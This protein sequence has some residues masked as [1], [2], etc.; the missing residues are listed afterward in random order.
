MNRQIPT[1]ACALSFAF[2]FAVASAANAATPAAV[3]DSSIPGQELNTTQGI[4]SI[5]INYP[6]ARFSNG[7]L[8]I[9]SG[10]SS[11]GRISLD[12]LGLTSVSVLVKYTDFSGFTG[13]DMQYPPVLT[14]VEISGYEV[15]IYAENDAT[16]FQFYW[17]ARGS[18]EMYKMNSAPGPGFLPGRSG[19]FLLSYSATEGIRFSLGIS[20]SSM[21]ETDRADYKYNDRVLTHVSIGG[22]IDSQYNDGWPNLVIEKVALF[23]GEFLSATD[24]ESFK[25]P[26]ATLSASEINDAYSGLQEINLTVEDGTTIQGDTTFTASKINF[27]CDGSIIVD[28]PAGNTTEFDFSQVEGDA[29]VSYTSMPSGSGEYFTKTTVPTWVTDSTRWTNTIALVNMSIAGPNFNNFGNAQSSIKLSGV[30]GWVNTGTEYAV[31]VVLEN[32]SYA[33]AFKLTNGNSPR[34]PANY[35]GQEN[36]CSVFHKISG[37]GNIVDGILA[38]GPWADTPWPVIKVYDASE[39]QGDITFD[40]A[41]LLICDSNTSYS[42][43]LY[44]LLKDNKGTLRIESGKSA[45]LVN[46][47]TWTV[48]NFVSSGI[49]TVDGTLTTSVSNAMNGVIAGAGNVFTPGFVPVGSFDHDTWSG[50]VVISNVTPTTT[51]DRKPLYP[52]NL[53]NFGGSNSTVRLTSI[54]SAASNTAY[55]PAATIKSKVVLSDDGDTPAL[56]LSDGLSDYCTTLH[57]LAGDGTFSQINAGISQGLTIN[58]MTNFTGSLLLNKMTVTFGTTTR[59]RQ[60]DGGTAQSKLFI[61]PDAVLSVPAGFA[62]WSPEAVVFNGPVNFTTDTYPQIIP[63]FTNIGASA[64]VPLDEMFGEHAA[65]MLNGETIYTKSGGVA[66]TSRYMLKLIGTNLMLKRKH[67]AFT[68]R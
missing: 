52:F 23:T 24:I 44:G 48:K 58:A 67:L 15:G 42:P 39:F 50:T 26:A 53:H 9:A 32:G 51:A 22:P 43:S 41:N 5:S 6:E 61:D 45:T 40:I 25:F 68:F 11:G 60:T 21:L 19:Y 1:C 13:K 33:F 7:K 65:I 46:G 62:L 12:G 56:R 37:R 63:L 38:S 35:P 36:R 55:L 3:W 2:A 16:D 29:V 8:L 66:G 31:P 28:P 34:D 64:N 18:S 30:Q 14:T 17:K 20:P 49:L 57:E 47:K 59:N 27:I 10:Q 54:G 4:Y